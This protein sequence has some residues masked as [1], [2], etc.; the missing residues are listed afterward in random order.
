M[1]SQWKVGDGLEWTV[2]D[3]VF[4]VILVKNPK[5]PWGMVTVRL[6]DG[7]EQL[8][9]R[10]QLSAPGS[11]SSAG[12]TDV[13]GADLAAVVH[14]VD[15]DD[16]YLEWLRD[17]PGGFVVNCE[18]RPTRKYLQLHRAECTQVTVLQRGAHTWTR[19]DYRKVCAEGIRELD[20][21]A[22]RDVGGELSAGC[23]CHLT[24]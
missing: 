10:D 3:Q 16:G 21:W 5:T 1:G 12:A 2:L 23:S 9:P 20:D 4:E 24:R 7:R 8:V 11:T 22:K 15:D 6:Q 17:H 13:A 19:G 14:F 18:R